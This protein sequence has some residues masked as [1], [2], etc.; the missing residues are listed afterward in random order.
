MPI[1]T[2]D[3]QFVRTVTCPEGKNKENY[4]DS[5]ITGFILEVRSS[6]GKTYAV[7]YR[8][9]HNRQI[10]QKIGDTQSISFDKAKNAAK[11]IRSRVVLGEDPASEKRNKRD[12]PTLNDYFRDR[13]LP[14]SKGYKR[15]WKS[16]VSIF[17][18]HLKAT[19]GHC[20]LDEISHQSVYEFH[21]GM[22]ADGYAKATCN[23]ALVLLKLL[24]N[25]GRRW[26]IPGTEQNPCT[27]V[28]HFEANNARE[29]FLT[30]EETRRLRI[31]LE[32]SDNPQLK[33]IIALLLLLG[34]RKRELLDS[35]WDQF[36]LERRSWRIPMSK[37]GKARHVPLSSAALAVLAQ[38][39]RW[40]RCPYVVPNPKSLQPFSDIFRSWNTAR[41]NAGLPDVRLHDLRHSMASNLV[42]SGRS[43]LEVSKI[44]GHSQ[45]KTTQRYAHLSQETLLA[46]VDAAAD[47]TG[48]NWTEPQDDNA[49]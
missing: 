10:Q 28:P 34:C 23:R 16:D 15:S 49:G 8:D 35:R 22:L 14:Y 27:D 46:A 11:V 1:V 2:L 40:E 21:H 43:I 5:S 41:K 44:L 3:A 29:R 42:N 31:E 19:F 36:D 24:Y 20:H 47:A 48:T 12:V 37:S 30:V 45:I 25:L 7:R 4:Y 18:N 9:S 39:P 38:L 32:K 6:G 26:K 13:F 33:N 17:R